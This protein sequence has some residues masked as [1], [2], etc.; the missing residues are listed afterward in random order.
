MSA[1][2]TVTAIHPDPAVPKEMLGEIAG[3]KRS[4][5][6]DDD[7]IDRL[8]V[9]TVPAGYPIHPWSPGIYT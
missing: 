6:T 3:W 8:R 5:L 7:V 2:G 9:R 4:G 1:D